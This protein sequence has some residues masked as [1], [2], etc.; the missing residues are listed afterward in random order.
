MNIKNITSRISY[1]GVNDRHTPLF[2]NLW[3]LPYGVT[4]NSYIAEGSQKCA[5]IDTVEISEISDFIRKLYRHLGNKPIDY[6]IINHMEPDHSGGIP[7]IMAHYPKMKLV[8]NKQTLSMVR[9]FYHLDDTRFLEIKD[10]DS[11]SLGDLTLRFIT[12]PMVH[13]PETMM[14]YAEEEEV[15]FTGDAFGTFGALAGAVVDRQMDPELYLQEMYRY[16]S[17]IVGKYGKFVQQA[18]TKIKDLPIRYLCPTHG[19]VWNQ[20]LK[21]VMDIYNRLSRYEPEEGTVI[22]YGSMYG[23]TA[24]GAEII[25]SALADNGHRHIKIHDA[26]R[27]SMSDMISDCFRYRNIVIGAPTYSMSLFPPIDSLMKALEVR[28]LKNRKVALFGSYS[29]APAALKILKEYCDRIGLEVV[30]TMEFKQSISEQ[31]NDVKILRD[32]AYSL[33]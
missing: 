33:K 22:I 18:L 21:E 1:V 3:P 10:G 6:L 27:S 19:P 8:G 32:L 23:H 31:T 29:W 26:S 5:L 11:L 16:Y 30:A 12:T 17:N 7:A 4:Y 28:G 2:E 25:A 24:E 15:I 13:W 9:G 14:T 20:N